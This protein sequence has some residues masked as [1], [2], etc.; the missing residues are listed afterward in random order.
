MTGKLAG[1]LVEKL[2][3][4]APTSNTII[5]VPLKLD[6]WTRSFRR[7]DLFYLF[8]LVSHF[9]RNLISLIS[10]ILEQI[11]AMSLSPFPSTLRILFEIL[12]LPDWNCSFCRLCPRWVC[13]TRIVLRKSNWFLTTFAGMRYYVQYLN[14]Q[15]HFI[16]IFWSTV[17]RLLY[18]LKR[19]CFSTFGD[20]PLHS[21]SWNPTL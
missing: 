17:E 10:S 3:P 2:V 14:V 16:E 5:V 21:F 6:G 9:E 11:T 4:L 19:E 18:S 15:N 1:P 12:P 13:F 8:S 7:S 20:T